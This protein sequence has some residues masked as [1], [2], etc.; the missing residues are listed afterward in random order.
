LVMMLTTLVV[1]N[2]TPIFSAVSTLLIEQRTAK[3]VSIEEIYGLEGTGTEYLQTQFE[4]LKARELA[5]RVVNELRLT[6]H[7]EFDPRQRESSW[8][9]MGKLLGDFDIREWLPM[10]MP[11]DLEPESLSEAEI[12]DATVNELMARIQVTP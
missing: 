10:V 9:D 2:M 7:P 1:F 11:E 5:E 8:L 4:L 12:F 3:P 6:E